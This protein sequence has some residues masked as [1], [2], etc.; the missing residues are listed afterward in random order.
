VKPKTIIERTKEAEAEIY[1]KGVTEGFQR[2]L[3]EGR[4]VIN[5]AN[6]CSCDC[7]NCQACGKF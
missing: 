2:C 3:R 4:V 5:S 7:L 6:R 1:N